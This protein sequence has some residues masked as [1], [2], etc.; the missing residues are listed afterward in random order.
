LL[1]RLSSPVTV[2]GRE[3]S[4]QGFSTTPNFGAVAFAACCA[5]LEKPQLAQLL[6][7]AVPA[8]GLPHLGQI[9]GL[10]AASIVLGS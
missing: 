6:R 3:H 10:C 2:K 5:T 1:Q 7:S 8:H 9:S 4:G